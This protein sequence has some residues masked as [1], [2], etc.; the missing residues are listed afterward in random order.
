MRFTR[1]ILAGCSIVPLALGGL[2]L[3]S[4]RPCA[5][6]IAHEYQLVCASLRL[7]A[8]NSTSSAVPPAS[9][10]LDGSSADSATVSEGATSES[11]DAATREVT[12][13]GEDASESNERCQYHPA[14]SPLTAL[15]AF[16]LNLRA[17]SEADTLRRN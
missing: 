5:R 8:E 9:P 15:C 14:H 10:T 2:I 17:S 3:N 12:L 11:V 16:P 1:G 7:S 6:E 4:Y 13:S